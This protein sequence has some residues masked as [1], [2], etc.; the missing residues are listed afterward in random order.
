MSIHGPDLDFCPVDY[1]KIT[2]VCHKILFPNSNYRKYT[3][4]NAS[5][6]V[7]A[8]LPFA[9]KKSGLLSPCGW[10]EVQLTSNC[11]CSSKAR[12]NYIFRSPSALSVDNIFGVKK[13][14]PSLPGIC[15]K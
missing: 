11:A 13:P 8:L 1:S 2:V 12:A 7:D 10:S 6:I 14:P 4:I 5:P 9:I 3:I 15:N